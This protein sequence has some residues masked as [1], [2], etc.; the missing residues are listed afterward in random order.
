MNITDLLYG[1]LHIVPVLYIGF[2]VQPFKNVFDTSL[3]TVKN[4]L[5]NVYNDSLKEP[6]YD[7]SWKM[8]EILTIFNEYNEKHIL[9]NFHKYTNYYFRNDVILIKGGKEIKYYKTWKHYLTSKDKVLFDLILKTDYTLND[10]NKNYTL[11]IENPTNVTN[12]NVKNIIANK[13]D[14]SFIVFELT[15]NNIKY[16]INFK[17]P[18]NF[19]VKDNIFKYTFFKWYMNKIHNIELTEDFTINYMTSDLSQGVL[20]YP[21]HIKFNESGLNSFSYKK[22]PP[23]SDDESKSEENKDREY[24]KIDSTEVDHSK[25]L[26]GKY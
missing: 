4:E 14:I 9:P 12:E 5:L 21:F 7:I 15:F 22:T 20:H 1:M 18:H 6:I 16:D 25:N 11:V 10:K 26:I 13:C 23:Q 8:L 3:I 17:S 24:E 19:F 2:N